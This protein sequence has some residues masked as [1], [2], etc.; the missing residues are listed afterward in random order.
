MSEEPDAVL[1]DPARLLTADR[2][3]LRAHLAAGSA[4][5]SVGR[6]VFLQA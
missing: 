2:A 1:A 3:E 4:A 6:E 5:E